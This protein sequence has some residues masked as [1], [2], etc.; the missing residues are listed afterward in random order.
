MDHPDVFFKR[1]N[2]ITEKSTR[3]QAPTKKNYLPGFKTS[4][5]HFAFKVGEIVKK[6]WTLIGV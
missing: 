5:R 1:R 3:V 2:P 4:L 6:L